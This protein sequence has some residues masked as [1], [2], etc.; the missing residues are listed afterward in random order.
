MTSAVK[1]NLESSCKLHKARKC[2]K[3]ARK[4]P[5]YLVGTK[6]LEISPENH[7][8]DNSLEA[9]KLSRYCQ[10]ILMKS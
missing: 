7:W 8:K 1:G 10:I 5:K 9:T 6:V 4:L 2:N 3:Y